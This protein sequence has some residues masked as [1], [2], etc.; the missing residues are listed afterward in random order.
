MRKQRYVA[1][2]SIFARGLAMGIAEIVP[3]ISGS[4]IALITG[5]YSRMINALASFSAASMMLLFREG[6]RPFYERHDV[7]FLLVLLVGM[8]FSYWVLANVIADLL[9]TRPLYVWGF[10]FGLVVAAV[11][12]IGTSI[13]WQVLTIL[14]GI[15]G[16]LVGAFFAFIPAQTT[17]PWLPLVFVGGI[18]AVAA[19]MLPGVSGS[20][21]LVLL[22]LYGPMLAA[23]TSLNLIVLST[24]VLGLLV[25]VVVF[26]RLIRH[27]FHHY[28]D[29]MLG[30]LTGLMAGSLMVLWPWRISTDLLWPTDYWTDPQWFAVSSLMVLGMATVFLLGF[31]SRRVD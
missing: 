11:I 21:V 26:A 27:L 25:G 30:L 15:F 9:E 12:Q 4:T 1:I 8:A 18:F 10:F 22:G 5:I 28:R 3:G 31:A 19:W 7:G 29:G 14:T 17:E 2:L 16:F 6:W 20:L 13:T 23:L 24:F